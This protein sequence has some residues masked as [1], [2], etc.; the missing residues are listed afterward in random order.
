[1]KM[2]DTESHIE[3]PTLD[4]TE[5]GNLRWYV[6]QAR[7]NFEKSVSRDLRDRVKR[8]GLESQF[9]E[10]LVPSEEVVDMKNGQKRK[11]ERKFFPG[12]VLVQIATNTVENMPRIASEAWHLVRETPKVLGFIGGMAD[13]PLPITEQEANRILDRVEA[14]E[15]KPTP[16]RMFEKGQMVRV[17]EGPFADFNGVV[18]DVDYEK[19]T[20]RTAVLVFGRSTPV[21][22]AINQVEK[23]S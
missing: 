23:A 8:A 7:A 11:T 14:A 4:E 12:Y 10:I 20:V 21:D 1:M 5:A 18:E 15:K 2:N 22:F 16:T 19:G 17:I 3:A 13:R 9:G 6:V